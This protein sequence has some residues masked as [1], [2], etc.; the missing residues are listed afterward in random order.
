MTKRFC[1]LAGLLLLGPICPLF[2]QQQS[3]VTIRGMLSLP[4]GGF[5]ESIGA[6]P[7]VTR[8]NGFDVGA[9]ASFA[10]EGLGAGIEI[11][12]PTGAQGL[13]WSSGLML[14]VNAADDR[15]LTQTFQ[16]LLGEGEVVTFDY[17]Y[18]IQLPVM[19]GFQYRFALSDQ[20]DCYGI[21]QGGIS[22]IHAATREASVSGVPV[23][24][25]SYELAQQFGY[26]LGGGI[27]VNGKFDL[28][29]RF[30]DFGEPAF[31]GTRS[32]DDAYFDE[33]H[34][35]LGE[36]VILGEERPVSMVLISVGYQF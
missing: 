2:G 25:R 6:N 3:Y 1:A 7:H 22:L 29:V 27:V 4:V 13:S 30:L 36:D 18:W 16:S 9:G 35:V 32:L 8:R 10:S 17:G 15:G 12:L 20:V 28:G 24:S 23:D 11:S 19:T 26:G 14:I 5:G 34:N 33:S 31:D 21:A